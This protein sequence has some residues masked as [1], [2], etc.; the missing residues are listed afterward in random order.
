MADVIDSTAYS[1][2]LSNYNQTLANFGNSNTSMQASL[3]GQ[4]KSFGDANAQYRGYVDASLEQQKTV[5][6]ILDEEINRLNA[7][8]DNINSAL[9]G[10]KRII[11]LNTSYSK[12][13]AAYTRIILFAVFAF[14][15]M[16]IFMLLKRRFPAIITDPIVTVVYIVMLSAVGI[17]A[18]LG[19]MNISSRDPLDFDKL[20]LP[21]PSDTVYE[22][23][24]AKKKR[25][26]AAQE[27]GRLSDMIKADSKMCSNGAC[28][29]DGTTFDMVS[30]KCKINT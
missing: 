9:S 15:I 13:I 29:G 17:Y 20:K 19:I 4:I 18:F 6:S 30:G 11:G 28:C 2:L 25:K 5:N 3:G 14:M 24:D 1:T 7:K 8:E 22:T 10:Q 23:E 16:V 12:R 27:S 21:P 26:N